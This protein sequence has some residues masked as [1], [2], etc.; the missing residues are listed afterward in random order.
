MPP[1]AREYNVAPTQDQNAIVI[2][3]P[4]LFQYVVTTSATAML[5]GAMLISVVAA[6]IN[7]SYGC[8]M[9]SG[10]CG[11]AFAHYF[12][13]MTIRKDQWEAETQKH[14]QIHETENAH[15]T[16]ATMKGDMKRDTK[17]YTVAVLRHS[18]WAVYDAYIHTHSPSALALCVFAHLAPI[19]TSQTTLPLLALKLL[20]QALTGP[21]TPTT[22][23]GAY[24]STLVGLLSFFTI[25]VSLINL[26]VF[27][28]WFVNIGQYTVL[29]LTLF[30]TS[31][32]FMAFVFVIILTTAEE[33]RSTHIVE[34]YVFLLFWVGYPL[35]YFL[36][37]INALPF[38]SVDMLFAPL[39]VMSKAIFALFVVNT[40]F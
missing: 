12:A 4:N 10:I 32:C 9:S 40:S 20:A 23:T 15:P 33:V 16:W 31:M 36:L 19:C 24:I 37:M 26:I 28:D 3:T 18:D 14:K 25:A 6:I 8:V 1:K 22:F 7:A 38:W 21:G 34:C 30:A 27:D 39:D 2:L 5:L 13:I 17:D 29:R 35:V 11:V